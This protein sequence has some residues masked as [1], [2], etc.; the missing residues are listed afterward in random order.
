MEPLALRKRLFRLSLA[1][2]LVAIALLAAW[3]AVRH[4]EVMRHRG[5]VRA[6]TNGT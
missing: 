4:A 2:G 3:V 6:A 1:V 5:G